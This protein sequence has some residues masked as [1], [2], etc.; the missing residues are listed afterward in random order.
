MKDGQIAEQGTHGQLVARGRDY[1]MLITSGQQEVQ[2]AT[3][4]GEKKHPGHS[5]ME[6]FTLPFAQFMKRGLQGCCFRNVNSF[7]ASIFYECI[8]L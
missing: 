5:L 8:D 6:C 4:L 3:T 7:L 2:L 1:A